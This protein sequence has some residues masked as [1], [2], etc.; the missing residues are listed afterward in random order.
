MRCPGCPPFGPEATLSASGSASGS[1]LVRCHH[2]S[3][4]SPPLLYFYTVLSSLANLLHKNSDGEG[5][6]MSPLPRTCRKHSLPLC[7]ESA[8]G[9]ICE[10]THAS[11][12]H[13][14]SGWFHHLLGDWSGAGECLG[15]G[16]GLSVQRARPRTRIL[17]RSPVGR[18]GDV[19]SYGKVS[20][21]PCRCTRA[22]QAWPSPRPLVRSC[23]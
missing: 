8:V 11:R 23:F 14:V 12:P 20:L 1:V 2:Q 22:D 5:F 13:P 17:P 3:A 6:C 16:A 7:P 10:G 19:R 21:V 9:P 15:P 4:R 18:P